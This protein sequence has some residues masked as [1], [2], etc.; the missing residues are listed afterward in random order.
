LGQNG[1][2]VKNIAVDKRPIFKGI[3]KSLAALFFFSTLCMNEVSSKFCFGIFV[4]MVERSG[5]AS[6]K[7]MGLVAKVKKEHFWQRELD[8]IQHIIICIVIYVH[9]TEPFMPNVTFPPCFTRVLKSYHT[10]LSS[11]VVTL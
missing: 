7:D 1:E 11:V 6:E 10:G 3:L 8:Q 9:V 5:E 2:S 4:K